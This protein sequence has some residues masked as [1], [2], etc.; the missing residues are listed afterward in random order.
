MKTS[1][2]IKN[3]QKQKESKK[4]KEKKKSP[5]E[6]PEILPVI[7]SPH[8][9]I[10]IVDESSPTMSGNKRKVPSVSSASANLLAAFLKRKK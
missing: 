1:K 8:K 5:Q 2:H 7:V 9:V 4:K 6:T 10:S 3:Q